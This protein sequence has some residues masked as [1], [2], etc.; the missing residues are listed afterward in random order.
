MEKRLLAIAVA[1]ALA[2]PAIALA[3]SSVS[4]NGFI[5]LSVDNMK[6]GN[7][8]PLRT[9]RTSEGRVSDESSSIVFNIREDLGSGL[10]AIVRVDFKPNLDSGSLASTGESWIGFS[11]KSWGQLTMG[12]HSLHYFLAP[13]D[14]YWKGVSYRLHPSSLTDFAGR[15]AVAMANATRTANTIKWT[16]PYWGGF[17]LIVAYSTNPL[18]TQAREADGT[19][20]NTARAGRG[21]NLHPTYSGPNWRIGYS[22][23]DAKADAPSANPA[24]ASVTA[25]SLST[26]APLGASY[27]LN[28]LALPTNG[29][30]LVTADQRGNTLYGHYIW[31]GWK[32][33]LL[34]NRSELKAAATG[35]GLAPVGTEIGNRTVWSLPLRYAT[36]QHNF[37][38]NYTRASDDKA[39]AARDGARMWTLA[40]AYD[41][42]KR[43]HLALAF[44]QLKNDPGGVYSHYVDAGAGTNNNLAAG[45]R[46]RVFSLG[47]RHDY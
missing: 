6:L 10:A 42:S 29:A 2:A 46:A 20:G 4:I 37:M 7:V 39:T 15:G 11:S 41:F 28:P 17:G 33:G 40:Y 47:I 35:A 13:D 45:E 1:G 32:F 43:T 38:A 23:W 25:A 44:N 16:S 8:N 5:Q 14:T 9:G 36:G 18:G 3:Q 30:Q 12:R 27:S 22:Y 26:L 19:Q 21:W 24:A 31:G 34:W